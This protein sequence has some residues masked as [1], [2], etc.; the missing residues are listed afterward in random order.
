M[1]DFDFVTPIEIR[2][3]NSVSLGQLPHVVRKDGTVCYYE[4]GAIVLDRYDP[5]GTVLQCLERADDVVR[6]AV[7]GRLTS[8]F[9]DEFAAYWADGQVLVDLP[10]TYTGSCK[11]WRVQF[12]KNGVK[13]EALCTDDSWLLKRHKVISPSTA[14]GVPCE[15]ISV[16]QPLSVGRPEA[17]PPT[18][19]SEL[20]VWLGESASTALGVIEKAFARSSDGVDP[21]WWT[22]LSSYSEVFHAAL[23]IRLSAGVPATDGRTGPIRTHA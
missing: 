18:T 11:I 7:R 5:A 8:D 16:P 22:P 9:R 21:V 23:P 19:L 3:L 4:P 6:D 1:I 12:A 2:I 10:A 17:W 14:T 13:H 20:N 15:V